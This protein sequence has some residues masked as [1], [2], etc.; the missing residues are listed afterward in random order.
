MEIPSEIDTSSFEGLTRLFRFAVGLRKNDSDDASLALLESR[1]DLTPYVPTFRGALEDFAR[2]L[3][4][5]EPSQRFTVVCDLVSAAVPDAEKLDD[6]LVPELLQICGDARIARFSFVPAILPCLL[7]AQKTQQTQKSSLAGCQI[8]YAGVGSDR[9]LVAFASLFLDLAIYAETNPPWD[10]DA[11]FDNGEPNFEPPDVEIAFPPADFRSNTVPH[12][13]ASVR[14]SKLP[15]AVDR[16][17][18]DLESVML[19]YLC[20]AE[21]AALVFTSANFLSSTKQSRLL[22]RQQLLDLSRI[23]QVTE[24]T[25]YQPHVFAIELSRAGRPNETIRMVVTKMV[26]DLTRPP[27]GRSPLRPKLAMVSV[28]D[29]RTAGDSLKPSRYL[30]T[31]PSGGRDF[32]E[33][34]SNIS[35]RP[36]YVLADF[37]EIIRPKTTRNDLVG[38]FPLQ[39]ARAGNISENGEFRGS[40]RKI[41]V[42]STLAV[43]LDEQVIKTGD[44]LFAHRGPV[45]K[46]AYVTD[47]IIREAKVWAGQTLMIFRA[48]KKSS[49]DRTTL[50]C[51]PRV[52]FMYLLTPDVQASWT[53]AATG[54]RSPAIPIGIIESFGLPDNLLLPQKPNQNFSNYSQASSSSYTD[55]IITE[56]QQRQNELKRLREIEAEMNDGLIRVW[57]AAWARP[58]DHGEL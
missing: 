20:E 58:T 27:L 41:N 5:L 34:M 36:K 6:E 17:K 28:D 13:E 35:G 12:L 33:M 9:D 21:G 16:G 51:D 48:R 42:R 37:F 50:Y 18:Y 53:R 22:T 11:V 45:G 40:F 10:P 29:V 32:T 46:V 55:V 19:A 39:E 4:A 49:T 52:L 38:T 26:H 25:I 31:G 54:D 44:I 1:F 56:F 2:Q 24:L 47:P 57:G 43:G 15:R 23:S 8:R 7:H 14:A 3:N 30:G